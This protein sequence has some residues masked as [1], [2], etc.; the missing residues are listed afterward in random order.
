[1]ERQREK[2]QEIPKEIKEKADKDL[3]ALRQELQRLKELKKQKDLSLQTDTQTTEVIPEVKEDEP[4][5]VEK[6]TMDDIES[7]LDEIDNFLTKQ[8]GKIDEGTYIR[9]SK[10]VE[11]QLQTL[12]QEIIGEKGIIQEEISPYEQLLSEYAWLEEIRYE[13]MYVVPDRKKNKNDYESWKS[14]WAKVLYDYARYAVLHVIYL[15]RLYNEKPFSKF[16]D[17][18][19]AVKEIIDALIDQN[20]AKW[21][22]KKKDQLRVY[23]KTLDIWANEIYDWA[24]ENGKIDPI[25]LYEIR[26]ANEQFSNLPKDDLYE[27]FKMLSKNDRGIVIK[28]DDGELALKIKLE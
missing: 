8:L 26:E 15:S 24:T 3:E 19:T 17:R 11:T 13:F 14:E 1:M 28:M 23:W 20:L 7:R 9:D 16:T 22:S 18:T 6:T 12:E 25:L 27:I 5:T 2:P 4:I 21:L 10:Y